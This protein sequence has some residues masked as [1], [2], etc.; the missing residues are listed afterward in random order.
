VTEPDSPPL[1]ITDSAIDAPEDADPAEPPAELAATPLIGPPTESPVEPPAGRVEPGRGIGLGW[2]AGVAAV[3]LVAATAGLAFAEHRGRTVT[4]V[5]YQDAPV[6]T[7]DAGGCPNGDN[8]SP[9]DGLYDGLAAAIAGDLP[10]AR[11]LY[12][13]ELLDTTTSQVNRHVRIVAL[14]GSGIRVAVLTQCRPGDEIATSR[15][16]G[17]TGT[18]PELAVVIRPSG[19]GCSIAV[20]ADVPAG[21]RVP[22]AALLRL[23]ADPQAQPRSP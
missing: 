18:G 10:D 1:R 13:G 9:L 14:A 7:V 15:D 8:C 16:S 17:L 3:A 6:H 22:A 20:L 19:P 11:E 23:A 4:S 2:C 12:A 21:A 5:R